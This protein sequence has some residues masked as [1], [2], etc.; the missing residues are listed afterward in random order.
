MKAGSFII[1]S[2]GR[3]IGMILAALLP[4]TGLAQGGRRGGSPGGGGGRNT[5]MDDLS[6][7]EMTWPVNPGFKD[8]VFTFARLRHVGVGGFGYGRRMSWQEDYPLADV[9]LSFRVHQIT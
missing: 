3:C 6:N 7:Q 9:M 4:L 8:D 2:H 1:G 5:Y